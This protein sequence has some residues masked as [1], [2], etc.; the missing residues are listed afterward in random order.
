MK[1]T[2][3]LKPSSQESFFESRSDYTPTTPSL[4]PQ[5]SAHW[6]LDLSR[7]QPTYNSV[8]VGEARLTST[9]VDW[10]CLRS[11][12]YWINFGFI[13]AGECLENSDSAR[14]T[15]PFANTILRQINPVLTIPINFFKNSF[16]IIDAQILQVASFLQVFYQLHLSYIPRSY[17]SIYPYSKGLKAVTILTNKTNVHGCDGAITG[18]P[19]VWKAKSQFHT[20][21]SHSRQELLQFPSLHLNRNVDGSYH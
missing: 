1:C 3:L 13:S 7:S 9:Q 8:S 17:Q 15:L 11:G 16:N 10:R 18:R 21:C 14:N 4:R 6:Y 2:R 12:S 5:H 19:N 20:T